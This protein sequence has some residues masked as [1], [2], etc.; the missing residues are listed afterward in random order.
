MSAALLEFVGGELL[1]SLGEVVCGKKEKPVEEGEEKRKGRVHESNL[2]WDVSTGGIAT[3]EGEEGE[4]EE[5]EWAKTVGG[6]VSFGSA[7]TWRMPSLEEKVEVK[8]ETGA[9]AEPRGE[10]G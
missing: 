3:I 1:V 7:L 8:A 2:R 5:E 9:E 10:A 6:V 4:E